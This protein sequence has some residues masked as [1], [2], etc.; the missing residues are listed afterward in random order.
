MSQ[1]MNA[2]SLVELT[3]ISVGGRGKQIASREAA[4]PIQ[5]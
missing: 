1:G 2:V 4:I 3:V 5:L